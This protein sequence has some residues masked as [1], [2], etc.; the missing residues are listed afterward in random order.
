MERRELTKKTAR[1]KG[2]AALSSAAATV[3]V[4]TLINPWLIMAGGPV[5][6]WLTYRWFKYRAE[7][8]LKF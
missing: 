2:Y 7:W 4:C 3:M 1:K 5:T 6:A 8:G